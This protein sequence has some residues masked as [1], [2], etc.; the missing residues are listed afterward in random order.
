MDRISMADSPAVWFDTPCADPCA[1]SFRGRRGDAKGSA[2]EEAVLGAEGE[3]VGAGSRPEFFQQISKFN[4]SGHSI[5]LEMTSMR[6]ICQPDDREAISSGQIRQGSSG[7]SGST[8]PD[9]GCLSTNNVTLQ[10]ALTGSSC[11]ALLCDGKSL[12]FLHICGFLLDRGPLATLSCPHLGHP[13][14]DSFAAHFPQTLRNKT[15]GCQ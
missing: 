15:F 5:R 3:G 9:R 12:C 6:L 7:M 14:G 10:P 2:R 11:P 1:E 8:Q 4:A 13:R